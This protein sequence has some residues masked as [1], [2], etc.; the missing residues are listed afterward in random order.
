MKAIEGLIARLARGLKEKASVTVVNPAVGAE[1]FPKL[2]A[3]VLD[4]AHSVADCIGYLEQAGSREIS[5]N[6]FIPQILTRV[7]GSKDS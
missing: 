1:I 3:E 2:K 6:E 5:A 7:I 4:L